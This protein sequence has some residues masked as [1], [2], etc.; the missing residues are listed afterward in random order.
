MFVALMSAKGAP[1]VTST[2]LCLAGA[3]S[4]AALVVEADSAG[5]DLECWSG[6]HGEAGL[7]GLATNLRPGLTDGQVRSH[8][9][10][11]VP[12]VAV[13]TAP[14]AGTAASAALATAGDGLGAALAGV[15]GDVLADLGRW[16]PTQATASRVAGAELVLVVCRPTL[17]SVEHARGLVAAAGPAVAAPVALV[18]VGGDQPYG[19]D[20]VAHAIGVPVLGVLPWE[21]RALL[22][23]V[24]H[25]VRDRRWQRSDLAAASGALAAAVT[26]AGTG[27]W[28]GA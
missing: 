2:T 13:V 7:V 19:P 23:L 4:P 25:G 22:G 15:D 9:V 14:T 12:G 27:A 1:G 24:S 28:T 11:A 17:D 16:S 20:E 26:R 5:G 18:L 21:P 6:P 8:A 3:Q 10:E